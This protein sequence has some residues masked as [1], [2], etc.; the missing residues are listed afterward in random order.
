MFRYRSLWNDSLGLT[1]LTLNEV[2]AKP[3]YFLA[4]P[5][6]RRKSFEKGWLTYIRDST[7]N[8]EL[9]R[10]LQHVLFERAM[11][12]PCVQYNGSRI[13]TKT[14]TSMKIAVE[15]MMLGRQAA[16][17]CVSVDSSHETVHILSRSI[18]V[19][20]I[21]YM[22]PFFLHELSGGTWASAYIRSRLIFGKM[23]YIYIYIYLYIYKT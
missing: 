16:C 6:L 3:M 18:P 11:R 14:T 1:Y 13:T 20:L 2:A 5:S 4:S 15:Q 7:Y 17:I 23:Q 8:R 9:R 10:K 21:G 12:R 19:H 22:D